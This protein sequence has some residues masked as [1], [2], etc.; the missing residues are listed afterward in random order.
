MKDFKFD[1]ITGPRPSKTF[2]IQGNDLSDGYHTFDELY[3]HRNF[4]FLTLVRC[5]KLNCYYKMVGDWVILYA[6]TPNGQISYHLPPK[7]LENVEAF[8]KKVKNPEWDHHS[9]DD[10]LDRLIVMF[11]DA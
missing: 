10:V 6:D 7:F 8:A 4:L 2:H 5:L 3:E 11:W 1:G 9:S